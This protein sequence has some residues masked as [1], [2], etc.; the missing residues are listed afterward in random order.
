MPPFIKVLPN[1]VKEYH[2]Y[3]NEYEYARRFIDQM[4]TYPDANLWVDS[5]DD[6][7]VLYFGI[8]WINILAGDHGHPKLDLLLEEVGVPLLIY[9]DDR[10]KKT[11]LD[12]LGDRLVEHTRLTYKSGKLDLNSVRSLIKG[13]PEG[14]CLERV[15][16]ETGQ[17][18]EDHLHAFSRTWGSVE[19]YVKKGLGY[20]IRHGDK[21]VSHAGSIF[22]YCDDL[23]VQVDTDPEY[24]RRGLATVV[25]ARLIEECLLNNITPYWDAHTVVSAGLAEKLG[26]NDPEK[27]DLFIKS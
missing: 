25:C 7:T 12:K 5:L 14:Y 18:I 22:P 16:L 9:P 13:L 1:R 21:V 26:F 6:P 2:R 8:P 24:R 19:N 4:K 20:C 10:W 11:L 17:Y 3:F 23:E 27:Y 15:S